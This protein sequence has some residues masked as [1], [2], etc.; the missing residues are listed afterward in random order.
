MSRKESSSKHVALTARQRRKST[1]QQNSKQSSRASQG[2][3]RRR[4]R[5]ARNLSPLWLVGGL[6]LCV[7]IVIGAIFYVA[8]HQSATGVVGPTDPQVLNEVT[9]IKPDVFAKVN[10]GAAQNTLQTT[11]SNQPLTGQGGKPEIF[12]YGSDFCPYCGALRWPLVVA[13]SRFGTFSKLPETLSS[14]QDVDPNTPTFTFSGSQYTS[15]Y[16]DFVPVEAEDRDRKPLQTPGPHEAPILKQYNVNG[17]PFLDLADRYLMVIRPMYPSILQGLSQKNIASRLSD[18][19]DS[20]TQNIVGGANYLTAAICSVTNNKPANVCTQEPIPTIE[21]SVIHSPS[22]TQPQANVPTNN[23]I[24][25][26]SGRRK[27]DFSA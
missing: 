25:L 3:A 9:H 15:R 26:S 4:R 7:V 11:G 5:E 19:S 13:L 17:F 12:Y 6:I 22:W 10:T 24:A 8:D 23:P 18:T 1:L 21:Q 14:S 27:D 16:I 20:L 2:P